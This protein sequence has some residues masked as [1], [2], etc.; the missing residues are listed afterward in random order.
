MNERKLG[1]LISYLN[2]VLHAVIGF[3]YVPILLHYI[4]KS[5]YGLYQL[6]GSFI[7]YFSIMDFGL[8][9]AVVRFYAK[10]KSLQDN[11]KMENIL[12][13]AM[14]AYC[15][16]TALMLA[17]GVGS[18]FY[19]PSIFA[20][21]MTVAEIESAKQLFILLLFKTASAIIPEGLL[22]FISHASGHSFSI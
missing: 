4:G 17:A 14:R 9:A 10:Y 21:S 16:I 12:A 20:K 18:Y 6:I 2:I 15:T 5:E 22:K 3:A 19:L 13:F 7:A 1:I 11:I 8:T